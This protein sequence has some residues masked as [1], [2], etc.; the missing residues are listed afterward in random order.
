MLITGRCRVSRSIS[1]YDF[2]RRNEDHIWRNRHI[3]QLETSISRS[4]AS[5]FRRSLIIRRRSRGLQSNAVYCSVIAMFYR[6]SAFCGVVA[7]KQSARPNGTFLGIPSI[8]LLTRGANLSSHPVFHTFFNF[9]NRKI[10]NF[11]D[12]FKNCFFTLAH[13]LLRYTEILRKVAFG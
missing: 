12:F 5:C 7:P 9:Y 11:F 8:R 10:K 3:F 1:F 6:S 13:R 2:F 4:R